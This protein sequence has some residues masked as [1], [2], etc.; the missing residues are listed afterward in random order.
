MRE[1]RTEKLMTLA[2][3]KELQAASKYPDQF[4]GAIKRIKWE[5]IGMYRIA[6]NR[7]KTHERTP[8]QDNLPRVAVS[9]LQEDGQTLSERPERVL[10][11]M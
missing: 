2:H 11:T 9:V 4:N 10:P 8:D 3:L 1:E 6:T 5:L 7:N